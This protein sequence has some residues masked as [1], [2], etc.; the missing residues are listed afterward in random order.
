MKFRKENLKL[1]SFM[2]KSLR[3]TAKDSSQ[4]NAS[5]KSNNASSEYLWEI[6]KQKKEKQNHFLLEI[7]LV[8][9]FPMKII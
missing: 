2:E 9:V 3:N 8:F 7:E 5:N 6:Y 4:S 1:L